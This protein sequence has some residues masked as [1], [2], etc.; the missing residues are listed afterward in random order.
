MD[1]KHRLQE[2]ADALRL[3]GLVTEC[4]G[5]D[6]VL[7]TPIDC[8][9]YDTR[10]ISGRTLFLCKGI[11]FKEEYLRQAKELGAVAY[12][13]ERAYDVDLP[14]ILVSNI[15]H[16][17]AA[18]APLYYGHVTD[19]LVSIGITGTKGKSTTVFFMRYILNAWLASLHRGPC[20]IV[21]SLETFDGRSAQAAHITTPEILDLYQIY[22]NAVN[23]GV[24]HMI[25]EVSS[26]ALKYER[27]GGIRYNVGCLLNIG[28]DHISPIEH[29]DFEDYYTSK[30]KIFD[31]S[32]V[33]IVNTDADHAERT[34][35]YAR[36]R[37][38][39][40]TFGSHESDDVSC[41]KIEKRS[42]GIYFTVRSPYYN[43]EFSLSMPGI[44]NVSN[45][46]AAI[47]MCGVLGIPEEYVR[48]GLRAAH[49]A[50]RM[51]V[52]HSADGEVTVVVDYAHNAMSFDALFRSARA[53]HPDCKL[54]A[55][56]GAVGGKALG[57]RRDLGV[58]A[59]KYADYIFLT[60]DDPAE[61]S[62]A[63]IAAQVAQYVTCPYEINV[64]R[65]D[66]I[67]KAILEWTGKRV[68]LCAGKGN[69][70]TQ[71]RGT[72]YVTVPSDGQWAR[73]YLTEY[74]KKRQK[75]AKI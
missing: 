52:Y 74:D 18:L 51:E 64:D 37:C 33:G 44:F 35:A 54:L 4:R 29:S 62:P 27:V 12:I 38:R 24:T 69:E 67:R 17:L 22:Q 70:T 25:N 72:E 9:T 5:L 47:A 6:D 40:V 1:A 7:Q 45:A 23:N 16:T 14:H 53:E 15:R 42:D 13:S 8:F 36:E 50:G 21:S 26:Q 66:C 57:R 68:V 73:E 3:A 60:E 28:L 55:V 30:L 32:E 43:G 59:S 49:V 61:E 46:L 2:Y 41:S 63:E 31:Q 39:V 11:H 75:D 56:F 10:K 48:A 20:A 19:K 65:G 71:K 58:T 34:L